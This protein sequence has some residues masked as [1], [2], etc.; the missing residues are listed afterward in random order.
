VWIWS[1]VEQRADE[2]E[3]G[4]RE[5]HDQAGHGEAVGRERA[6][7]DAADG[8]LGAERGGDVL[9]AHRPAPLPVE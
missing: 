6:D 9:D 8:V 5:D 7:P 2:A 3:Q 4:Q 1:V